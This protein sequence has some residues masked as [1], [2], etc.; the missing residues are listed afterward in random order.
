MSLL[1]HVDRIAL[2]SIFAVTLG[3]P[4]A[5]IASSTANAQSSH[6][7]FVTARALTDANFA[8]IRE[9]MSGAE[10]VARI[11]EP[12]GKMRFPLS[13]TTAWDYHFTDAWNYDSEF[14]VIVDDRNIVVGKFASRNVQ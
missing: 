7:I 6:T 13:K 12:H 3:V 10:V 1:K 8:N 5:A 14:S 9:G 11:G 4:A 2:L